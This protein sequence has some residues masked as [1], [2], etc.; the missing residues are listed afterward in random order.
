ML[1]PA[2][3][4][5][6][7]LGAHAVE[8]AARLRGL[9]RP[10]PDRQHRIVRQ[11][12]RGPS[13]RIGARDQDAR[14]QQRI[15]Q[16]GLR[17]V[18]SPRRPACTSRS[19]KALP[20]SRRLGEPPQQPRQRSDRLR[21]QARYRA[22][23]FR[24]DRT[25][26]PAELVIGRVRQRGL[27]RDLHAPFVELPQR[28][29]QQR[30]AVGGLGVGEQPLAKRRPSRHP[31]RTPVRPPRLARARSRRVRPVR[32]G[33]GRGWRPSPSGPCNCRLHQQQ[34]V[35]V[36]AQRRHHPDPPGRDELLEA[37]R[38]GRAL[39]VARPR[40]RTAPRTDR[41]AARAQASGPDRHDA[42]VG[43]LRPRARAPDDRLHRRGPA[44]SPG[45]RRAR[46]RSDS[47]RA[48]ARA[49]RPA[50]TA[51]SPARSA[52]RPDSRSAS[53]A[54]PATD[55]PTSPRPGVVSRGIRPARA[56]EDLPDPLAPTISR[57][58][59]PRSAA[60]ASRRR[61]SS[62]TRSRPK[63]TA[64]C[65][66]SNGASPRNGEPFSFGQAMRGPS[67]PC[68]FEPLPQQQLDLLLEG[69]GVGE[70]LKRGLELPRSRDRNHSLQNASSASELGLRLPPALR[71]RRRQHRIGG[72]AEH[73]D[74]RHALCLR[75]LERCEQ[76][77]GRPRRIGLAVWHAGKVGGKLGADARPEDRHHDVARDRLRESAAGSSG[78]PCRSAPPTAPSRTRTRPSYSRLSLAATACTRPRSGATSFG[79]DTKIVT[80]RAGAPGIGGASQRERVIRSAIVYRAQG[81][82][83][84]HGSD[85][86]PPTDTGRPKQAAACFGPI[87][88]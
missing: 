10:R 83:Q 20:S 9:A 5:I 57:N 52:G 14:R 24:R 72:L 19:V 85:A 32:A 71:V 63:N 34:L 59:V 44:A 38:K 58:G 46:P 45:C 35:E 30:Q 25:R 56:S 70:V 67:R 15:D 78:R 42:P 12:H 37:L 23:R 65:S 51:P 69:I 86:R 2:P 3:Q 53:F 74:V 76:L 41:S 40:R 21:R 73:V 49:T 64:A 29:L 48:P 77:V 50:R 17:G 60:A 81:G 62:I 26:K 87:V 79:E 55:R 66:A 75:C 33:R 7:D 6:L 4:R 61:A 27:A 47:R 39:G 1:L 68:V 31:S 36:G 11:P 28:E 8:L 43:R 80:L 18:G 82:C 54:P 22:F 88:P 16:R 13:V 84:R